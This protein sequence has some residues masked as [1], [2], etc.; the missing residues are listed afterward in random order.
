MVNDNIRK[1]VRIHNMERTPDVNS[2]LLSKQVATAS[3][4]ASKG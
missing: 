3:K 4:K 2:K 1:N